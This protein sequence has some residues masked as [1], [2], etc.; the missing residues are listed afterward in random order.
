MN[1]DLLWIHYNLNGT[2]YFPGKPHM[3]TWRSPSQKTVLFFPNNKVQV[4][5]KV[6][7]K[8][9]LRIQQE[10]LD[11]LRDIIDTSFSLTIPSVNTMTWT[12]K[13]D[14]LF[15]FEGIPANHI[16]SYEP[17][18]FP[19]AIFSHWSPI[20]VIVFPNGHINI[21]GVKTVNVLPIIINELPQ[22]Y[23]ALRGH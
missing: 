7:D 14:R 2:K 16:Y 23:D 12:Y 6:D 10:I 11:N 13:Y 20:K 15:R 22:K 1:L 18:V 19:A 9:V 3:L 5:G 17:E 8:L 4:I 21:V